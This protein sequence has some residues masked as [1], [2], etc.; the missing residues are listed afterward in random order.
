MKHGSGSQK[1]PSAKR[2]ALLE[3]AFKQFYSQGITAT[4][5]DGVIAEAGVAK[6]TLYKHFSSKETMIEATLDYFEKMSFESLQARLEAVNG[7]PVQKILLVFSHFADWCTSPGFKGCFMVRAAAEHTDPQSAI[8]LKC[9]QIKKRVEKFL[10]VLCLQA[11]FPQPDIVASQ[12]HLI[13]EGLISVSFVSQTEV[14]QQ[15]F[16]LA[17]LVLVSSHPQG[18]ALF[19]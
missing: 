3:T 10:E 5:I 17:K 13:L 11:C 19:K 12:L 6:M 1:P 2:Q 7:S 8:R 14:S 16:D 4:G 15:A 9:A 18:L